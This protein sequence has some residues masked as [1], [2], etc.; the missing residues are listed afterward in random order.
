MNVD[1]R[2]FRE[3]VDAIGCVY[4]DVDRR[5][6]ND[7]IAAASSTPTINVHAG[8]QKLCG[9][10]ALDY[11]RYRHDDNDLV[12]AARQQDFLRQAKAQVGVGKIVDDRRKLTKASASTRAPTS[13]SQG[14][15]S[16][17]LKL[18]VASADHPIREVHFQGRIGASYVTA[19]SRSVRKV[20]AASSSA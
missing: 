18:V 6:F 13:G 3:A 5:Y 15:C 11:V 7:N 10:D 16:R 20:D 9:Q 4:A 8:Y 19:S 1:F 12:R 17:L 14:R 2:G